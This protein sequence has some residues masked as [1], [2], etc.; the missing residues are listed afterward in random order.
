MTSLVKF[1]LLTFLYFVSGK[2]GLLLAVPPGYATAVWP[3]S[4][5]AL[6]GILVYG[7]RFW[8]SIWLGS[9]L[10]NIGT[11]IDAGSLTT[12]IQS[13]KPALMIGL[14]ASLQAVVGASIVRRALG[15]PISLVKEG[16]VFKFLFWAGPVSCITN[17]T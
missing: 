4:G 14:G 15:Y 17:A 3:P 10:V 8:P 13:S 9:F 2:L 6:A 16:D 1:L 12:L 7:N 11:S 5:F